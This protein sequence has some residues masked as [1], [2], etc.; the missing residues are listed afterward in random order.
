MFSNPF[1]RSAPDFRTLYIF[2]AGG[3]GRE[4]AWLA[5]QLWGNRVTRRFL[6]NDTYAQTESVDGIGVQSLSS[7]E[8]DDGARFVV[9]L[10][11]PA[12]RRRA[13]ME[14]AGVGLRPICI[15]HPRAEM[16]A[17]VRMGDGVIVCAGNTVTTG[18]S[19][20]AHV[21]LNLNCTVSHDVDIGEFS[22]LSPGVH[23]SGHVHI[24]SGVFIGTG[25]N[26]INGK[27]GAPLTIGDGAV[28]AAGAC[29]TRSVEPG[30]LMAGVPAVRK[31]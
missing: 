15:V 6:V 26:I 28:I 17:R 3:H 7:A 18:V 8:P 16:S 27:A 4:V 5:E 19:L 2:G 10:G 12:Q 31:R 11:D 29:V 23:I 1:S 30:S 25:V 22:T 9:A 20:A 21:H 14:C 24:G 13:A